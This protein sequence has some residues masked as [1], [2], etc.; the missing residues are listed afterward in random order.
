MFPN[1]PF[2]IVWGN[3]FEPRLKQLVLIRVAE[4][5]TFIF[6]NNVVQ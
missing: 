6:S 5:I 4:N 2:V 3:L 1:L